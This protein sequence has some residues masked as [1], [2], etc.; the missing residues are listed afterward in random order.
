MGEAKRK[1]E[2]REELTERLKRLAADEEAAKAGTPILQA[3]TPE[4]R[5]SQPPEPVLLA[6]IDRFEGRAE[7]RARP[8]A[9]FHE[10]DRAATL[11]HQVDLA[12]SAACV[13]LDQRIAG[14]AQVIPGEILAALAAL[15]PIQSALGPAIAAMAES[16]S[17]SSS[18]AGRSRPEKRAS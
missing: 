11:D 8:A 5:G 2:Y 12:E 4:I 1:E 18:P 9:D 14:A 6:G 16:T 15:A 3:A 17:R 13:A 10:D 7:A